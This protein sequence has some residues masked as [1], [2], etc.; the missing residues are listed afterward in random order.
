[1]FVSASLVST[2]RAD[3]NRAIETF[4]YTSRSS[5]RSFSGCGASVFSAFEINCWHS[6]KLLLRY[7]RLPNHEIQVTVVSFDLS[8]SVDLRDLGR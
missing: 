1:M 2:I 5:P 4:D 7:R 6:I 8:G 3:D